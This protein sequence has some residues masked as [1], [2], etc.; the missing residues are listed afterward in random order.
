M[1]PLGSLVATLPDWLD[2]KFAKTASAALAIAALILVV[3]V[4][5]LVRSVGTRLVAV[6]LLGA[7][8]FGLLHYRDSLTHCDK[9][10][11]ACKLFGENLKG[12][13]CASR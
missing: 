8:V 5:F 6:V 3:T 12:G 11:C 4:I 10:G 1:V 7:A 13:G 2:L 9:T